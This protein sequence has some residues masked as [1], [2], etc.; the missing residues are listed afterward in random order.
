[1]APAQ[2]DIFGAEHVLEDP[3]PAPARERADQGRLFD[4]W[5]ARG[6]QQQGLT[7]QTEGTDR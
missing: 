7:L 3:A 2:L 4:D 6:W 5:T 1:M